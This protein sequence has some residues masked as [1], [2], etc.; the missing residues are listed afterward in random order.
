M[1]CLF[2][3]IN[4]IYFRI[5]KLFHYQLHVLNSIS[6]KKII[7]RKKETYLLIKDELLYYFQI[8]K[9]LKIY[10]TIKL[11]ENKK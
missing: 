10:N 7:F 5:P 6:Y 2:T 11:F 8:L 3:L 4:I 1:K 9:T